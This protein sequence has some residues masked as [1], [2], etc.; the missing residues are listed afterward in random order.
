[1]KIQRRAEWGF[2]GLGVVV[3]LIQAILVL[4]FEKYTADGRLQRLF[5]HCGLI[6]NFDTVS[7]CSNTMEPI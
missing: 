4:L 6:L 2:D 1:M 7:Q 5:S 3:P